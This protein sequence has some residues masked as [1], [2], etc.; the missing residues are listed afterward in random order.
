MSEPNSSYLK[1]KNNSRE[2][3]QHAVAAV[4]SVAS[5]ILAVAALTYVSYLYYFY[6]RTYNAY[7]RANTISMAPHVSGWVMELPIVDNQYVKKGDLLFTVD[8][9]PYLAKLKKCQADL[10]YSRQYLNRVEKLLPKH[11]VTPNDVFRARSQVQADEAAMDLAK[12]NVYYCHVRAPFNGY[13]TN[14]NISLHEYAN[15]GHPVLTLVDD[16]TWYVLANYRE[17]FVRFIKPG[18]KVKVYVQS[19]PHRPF[20]AHVEGLAWGIHAPGDASPAKLVPN[21]E[22][23]LDWVVL[24]QRIPVRIILDE[25]DTDKPFRMGQTAVVTMNGFH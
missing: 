13:V 12:I 22:P 2:L 19:Y 25:R 24:S 20:R 1:K 14:L 6:P 16:T 23:T 8:D 18:M 17:E 4:I 5:I 21:V 15:E 7:I 9:R 3:S 11:F 10:S